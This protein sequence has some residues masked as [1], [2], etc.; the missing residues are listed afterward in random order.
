MPPHTHA[1]LA[2]A[3]SPLKGPYAQPARQQEQQQQRLS[4]GLPVRDFEAA[5]SVPWRGFRSGSA[6][7]NGIPELDVRSS[8]G[9][10]YDADT[11]GGAGRGAKAEAAARQC[12]RR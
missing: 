3:P 12:V 2:A 11:L 1:G 5:A 9:Y 6:L 4:G 10:D 8:S 7:L